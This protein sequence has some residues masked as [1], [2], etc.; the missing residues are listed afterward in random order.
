MTIAEEVIYD[1]HQAEYWHEYACRALAE[2]RLNDARAAQRCS[3]GYAVLVM[4]GLTELLY[5]RY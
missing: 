3:R 4:K 2:G 1:Q 5:R